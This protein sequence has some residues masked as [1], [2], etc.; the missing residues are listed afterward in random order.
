MQSDAAAP[1]DEDE[2]GL[3]DEEEEFDEVNG[4]HFVNCTTLF[5]AYIY[6]NSGASDSAF[7]TTTDQFNFQYQCLIN[8]CHCSCMYVCMYVCTYYAMTKSPS[9]YYC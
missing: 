6:V 8:L 1:E 5:V 9:N 7:V 2:E 4:Y 3:M